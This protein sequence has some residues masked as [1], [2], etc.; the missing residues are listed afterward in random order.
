MVLG[1]VFCLVLAFRL[2]FSLMSPNFSDSTSYFNLRQVEH[3]KETGLPLYHDDLSYSGRFFVFLPFFHYLLAVF[4]IF[5]PIMVV[6]KVLPAIFASSLVIISYFIALDLTNHKE[7]AIFTALIS[8]FIPIFID[9]TINTVSVYTLAIP[10]TLATVYFLMKVMGDRKYV[11]H[12]LVFILLLGL[13]N[14][15]VFILIVSLLFYLVLVRLERLKPSRAET[16][17]IL[18]S[19]FFIT[20][21]SFVV[22]KRAFLSLGPALIWQNLPPT[23]VT[24]YFKDF[25]ILE[26]IYRIGIIPFI[27]GFYIIYKTVFVEK[28]R[29]L[30]LLIAFALTV[31]LLVWLRLVALDM[32]LVYLSVLLTLLFSPFYRALIIYISKTRFSNRKNLFVVLF[33][34]VFF[35]SSFFPGVSYANAAITRAFSDEQINAFEWIRE[36]TPQEAVVLATLNEGHLV[37]AIANRKNVADTNFLMQPLAEQRLNDINRIYSTGF[38][39]EAIRLLNKYDVDYIYF[40]ELAQSQYSVDELSYVGDEKCFK[41]VYNDAVKIYKSLCEIDEEQ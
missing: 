7:S 40:S 11:P 29:K 36:N 22:F 41:L 14:A 6:G 34:L 12:F 8:G 37:N 23:I 20:W 1:L 2:S 13:T 3:I 17:L 15:S 35:V 5:L 32:G 10:L 18:F 21:L 9:E 19:G 28:R 27:F 24:Q 39:I 26:A 25:N 16:E 33:L 31:L 38:E 4:S 30:Y